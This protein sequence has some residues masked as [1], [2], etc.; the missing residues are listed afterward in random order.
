MSAPT[1]TAQKQVATG[2]LRTCPNDGEP[3]IFTFE[4]P[5]H[6]YVCTQC[7]WM[8]GVLGTPRSP[9]TDALVGRH[10]E[11]LAAFNEK[12]GIRPEPTLPANP[13]CG[14]CKAVAPTPHKPPHWFVRTKDGVDQYACCRD[15]IT[16]GMVL[17][18]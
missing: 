13:V 1:G 17:P 3:V 9:A 2:E 4:N 12:R 7:G 14:G 8:G 6:E 5:G 11:L 10:A 18:W 15:C 16:D